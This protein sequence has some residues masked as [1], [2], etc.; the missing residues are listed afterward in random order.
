MNSKVLFILDGIVGKT[1]L[2]NL[3]QNSYTK[4]DYYIV[5]YKE[6][7][8]DKNRKLPIN[9]KRFYFDP[10]SQSKLFNILKIDFTYII[11]AV[12]IKN[13]CL[14]VKLLWSPGKIF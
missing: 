12:N 4:N 9:V 13:D 14:E 3:L 1:V 11:I 10:T 5:S 2:E 8:D 7:G 6:K